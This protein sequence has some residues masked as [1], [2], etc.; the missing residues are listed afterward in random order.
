MSFKVVAT[1]LDGTLLRSDG[2]LSERTRQ[3]LRAVEAHGVEVLALTARPPR[4]MRAI[5]DRCGM[6]ALAICSNGRC[7][8]TLRLTA[9]CASSD[10]PPKTWAND[11]SAMRCDISKLGSRSWT[12]QT[13]DLGLLQVIT[14]I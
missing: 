11:P 13:C 6:S 8:T 7:S 1:D 9:S 3:A 14:H 5:A 2:T 4:R 10:F 12:T